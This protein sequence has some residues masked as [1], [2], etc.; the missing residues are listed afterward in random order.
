VV[1]P[2]VQSPQ[3]WAGLQP[4]EVWFVFLGLGILCGLVALAL[5]LRNWTPTERAFKFFGIKAPYRAEVAATADQLADEVA[6]LIAD[7]R[8]HLEGARDFRPNESAEDYQK[9]LA[10][11][12]VEKERAEAISLNTYCERYAADVGAIG[13]SLYYLGI[14]EREYRHFD[15]G[16]DRHIGVQSRPVQA[17]HAQRASAHS[18]VK[19]PNSRSTAERPR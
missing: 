5:V 10:A 17:T 11:W 3:P 19:R 16:E 1:R 2:W 13:W 18:C 4:E 12:L 15:I 6:R 14:S 9:P 7:H 8:A